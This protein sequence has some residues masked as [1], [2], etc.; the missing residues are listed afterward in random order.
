MKNAAFLGYGTI[1][2]LLPLPTMAFTAFNTR[3]EGRDYVTDGSEFNKKE[4]ARL[5]VFQKYDELAQPVPSVM[6][7]TIRRE[8]RLRKHSTI[9]V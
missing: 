5:E 9:A 4:Q 2:I 1:K 7:V 8:S 3:Q 6:S